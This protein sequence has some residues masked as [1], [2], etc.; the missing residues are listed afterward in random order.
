MD[1]RFDTH[2]HPEISRRTK[3]LNR[4]LLMELSLI[5]MCLMT[6]SGIILFHLSEPLRTWSI[7]ILTLC[8]GFMVTEFYDT[9]MRIRILKQYT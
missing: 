3:I 2:N 7:V 9:L 5:L 8:M 6:Y 4:F 1:T